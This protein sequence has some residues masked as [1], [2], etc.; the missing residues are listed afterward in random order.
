M[1]EVFGLRPRVAGDTNIATAL[2]KALSE[3]G[4]KRC[5][6]YGYTGALSSSYEGDH[7][8]SNS[9]ET[10]ARDARVEIKRT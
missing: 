9:R 7:K 5:R 2:E 1:Q 6:I 10:R 3:R 8:T 4:Y